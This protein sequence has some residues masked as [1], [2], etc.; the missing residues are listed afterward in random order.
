MVRALLGKIS[1]AI[2]YTHLFIFVVVVTPLMNNNFL[3]IIC[4]DLHEAMGI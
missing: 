3:V 4:Q 2:H 1:L